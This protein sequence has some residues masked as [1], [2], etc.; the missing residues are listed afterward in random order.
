MQ[1]ALLFIF[2][3]LIIK[4]NCLSDYH[5]PHFKDDRTVI[6]QMLEWRFEDIA[7]E[8]EKFL[9]PYG[10]GG[11][12][13]SPVSEHVILNQ[14]PR[15]WYERYQPISY[16]LVTR[17]GNEQQFKDMVSR[18][19]KAGVRIYIDVV[20]NHMSAGN[21]AGKGTAGSEYNGIKMSFPSVPFTSEHFNGYPKCPNSNLDIK[22]YD[23]PN[24]SRNCRLLNLVD[25]NNG[26]NHVR[27]KQAEF[28]NKMIDIGV[29]GFR[30][31]ASK[32]MWP[33]DLKEIINK[34]HNLNTEFFPANGKPF[35]Y[36]EVIYYGGNSIKC[37]EYLSIGRCIEFKHP[38]NI[39]QVF[40]KIKNQKLK[41]FRNWG[42]DWGMINS[43]DALAMIDSHDLQRGQ[44]GNLDES[45][46]FFDS[47]LLKMSTAFMLAWPYGVTRIMSSYQ[48]PRKIEVS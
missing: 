21:M 46:S 14:P 29:A 17:S 12:Q 19:N 23:D 30:V 38:M 13:T 2:N 25:V 18:C 11:V 24:Q 37:E 31:D 36:H 16:K 5:D 22:N 4:A 28:L 44:S 34:L 48:W 32:H 27:N 45:I 39:G 7:I 42:K 35:F 9:G 41:W 1:F 8:C 3:L 47:K 33:A 26:H 6:V 10:F 40:R 43:D 20:L 15:P